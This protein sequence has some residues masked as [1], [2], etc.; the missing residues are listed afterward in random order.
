MKILFDECV[1]RPL[2]RDLPGHHVRTVADMGWRGVVNGSLLRR[3]EADFDV[4]IT[5]DRNMEQQ[6]M[7][8]IVLFAPRNDYAHLQ[9]L[10]PQVC[11][12]RQTIR[13]GEVVHVQR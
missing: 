7:A 12:V 6:Q 13:M 10:L 2:K 9:P 5:V 4:F 1:P 8:I 11:E 3:A